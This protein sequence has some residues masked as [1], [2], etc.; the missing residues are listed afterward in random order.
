MRSFFIFPSLQKKLKKLFKKDKVMYEIIM[1][2]IEEICSCKN[3]N[4]YKNLRNPLQE[5]KRV[6][7]KS[8]FVLIFK[9][10]QDNIEFYNL[11]HHDNIYS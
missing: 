10:S 8:S 11:D 3:I 7:I 9:V 5:F 6:H 4:H 1:K 2:K